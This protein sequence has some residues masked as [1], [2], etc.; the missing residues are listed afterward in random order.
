M[1][2][3]GADLRHNTHAV[4]DIAAGEE[5][6]ISYLD[7][8]RVRQVRQDRARQSWG[9]GCTCPHC[10][11]PAALANASDNRLS[12]IYEVENSLGNWEVPVEEDAVELLLSMYAQERM[13]ASH[14]GDAYTLAALNYN[15][16]GR[17]QLAVKYALLALEQSLLE[18]G[19]ASPYIRSMLQLLEDPRKHWSW[20][21]RRPEAGS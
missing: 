15:A 10:S 16:F 5:L 11:L 13:D 9:F 4:R 20:R 12:R 18:N 19:A 21:K 7:S 8:F 2:Y 1:Y 14:G 17:E 6:A 3:V